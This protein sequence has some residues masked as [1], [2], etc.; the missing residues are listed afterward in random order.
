MSDGAK[1]KQTNTMDKW[2]AAADSTDA[3]RTEA[4]LQVL[5]NASDYLYES[6][7]PNIP[8]VS[9][10]DHHRMLLMVSRRNW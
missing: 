10:L 1:N 7:N 3:T 5:R 8:A 9:L 6:I 4:A 2:L